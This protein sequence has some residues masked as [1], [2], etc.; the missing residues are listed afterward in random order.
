MR[1]TIIFFLCLIF[2]S[3]AVGN[4]QEFNDVND[5]KA[6]IGGEPDY[7]IDFEDYAIFSGYWQDYCPD[8]W[9]LK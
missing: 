1:T 8:G 5:F 3:M 9:Q 7:K 6:A 4:V 2:T